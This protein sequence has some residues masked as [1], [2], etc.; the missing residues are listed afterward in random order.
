MFDTKRQLVG[1]VLIFNSPL[2]LIAGYS[3]FIIWSN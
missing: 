2:L 3:L 1:W